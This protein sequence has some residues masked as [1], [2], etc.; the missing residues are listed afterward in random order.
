MLRRTPLPALREVFDI[1]QL[2]KDI[3][4][5]V[6]H[7]I[8]NSCNRLTRE[9]LPLPEYVEHLPNVDLIGRLSAEGV[10]HE[11]EATAAACIEMGK[12]LVALGQ[13][14][15]Q[16][17]TEVTEANNFCAET[18]EVVRAK[19]K[20]MFL[21]IENASLRAKEARAVCEE[22]RKKIAG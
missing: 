1:S 11:Y 18:A 4:D 20:E 21:Q 16:M 10:L 22:M 9:P 17:T 8:P 5:Q 2:E 6:H 12:E 3:A 14:V 19:A 13:A 7:H 15:V